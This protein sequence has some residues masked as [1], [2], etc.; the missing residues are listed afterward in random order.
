MKRKLKKG[1]KPQG[2][3]VMLMKTAAQHQSTDP[4]LVPE[5]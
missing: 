4:Q 2:R 3:Q 5:Q 1:N